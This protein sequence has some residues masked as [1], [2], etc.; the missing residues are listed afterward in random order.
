[1]TTYGALARATAD[2]WESVPLYE[3]AVPTQLGPALW[4]DLCS[5]RF[6]G[7]CTAWGQARVTAH[8]VGWVRYPTV[9]ACHGKA[10][11]PAPLAAPPQ[12]VYIIHREPP[13]LTV[14]RW[15]A[16]ALLVLADFPLDGPAPD[17]HALEERQ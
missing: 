8:P 1:M 11:P 17:W 4:Q 5:P 3:Q 15:N 14:L 16:G 10:P 2:G 6:W 12:W 7:N 9:C 13:V